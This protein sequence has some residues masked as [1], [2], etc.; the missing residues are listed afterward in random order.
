MLTLN[1]IYIL[2]SGLTLRFLKTRYMVGN[3]LSNVVYEGVL[4]CSFGCGIS[5]IAENNVAL[6]T[7]TAIAIELDKAFPETKWFILRSN[8]IELLK[9]LNLILRTQN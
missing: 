9:Y 1:F 6:A 2:Y 3:F 8:F 4:V 7:A 5:G